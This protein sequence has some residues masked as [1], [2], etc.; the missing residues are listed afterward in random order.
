MINLIKTALNGVFVNFK[1]IF[2]ASNRVTDMEMRKAILSGTVEVEKTVDE[3]ACIGC[4]GCANVCPTQAIEMKSL[5]RPVK[6]A[7]GWIKKEVPEIN[8]EKCVVCY[9]CHDFCPLYALYG[10]K[11]AVHPNSVGDFEVD[12]SDKINDPIK[13]SEDKLKY[14][15]Q[16]LSDK[17]IL[18]E[19][20]HGD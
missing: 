16:Y 4:S 7:E 13:I 14:I 9:Y 20:S 19:D 15:S 3:S 5:T 6:I 18:K 8:K 1:R 11:G 17:T 2:F 12:V 10:L